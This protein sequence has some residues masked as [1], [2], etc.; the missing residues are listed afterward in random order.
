MQQF[1]RYLDEQDVNY[2]RHSEK[3]EK[4]AQSELMVLDTF[5]ELPYFYQCSAVA[6]AGRN[7]GVLEPMRF[8]KPVVVG[9]HELWNKDYQTSYYT[10]RGHSCGK[11]VKI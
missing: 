7:H 5:G 11:L 3:M 10:Q 8:A 6:F 9:L 2:C 1:Y 4:I